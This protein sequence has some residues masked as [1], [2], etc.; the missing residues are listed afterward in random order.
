MAK[1]NKIKSLS[2]ALRYINKKGITKATTG[3]KVDADIEIYEN[4][5][6]KSSFECVID[7]NWSLGFD[8]YIIIS[9]D[10]ISKKDIKSGNSFHTHFNKME[11]N[12]ED[13]TLIIYKKPYKVFL[14]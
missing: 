6:W 4:D 1:I 13:E 7:V 14:K 8:D 11:Y 2:A 12:K 10:N 9:S 3:T 5:K